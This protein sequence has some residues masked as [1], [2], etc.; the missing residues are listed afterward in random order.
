[1]TRSQLENAGYVFQRRT[2]CRG[3]G[4]GAT[5]EFWRRVPGP[6]FAFRLHP[7]TGELFDHE[8][9]CPGR[10]ELPSALVEEK[11]VKA[12][13]RKRETVSQGSLFP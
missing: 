13:T 4:C 5:C 10:K 1:M 7:R 8:P 3:E 11:P 2:K 12:E 9:E 6:E